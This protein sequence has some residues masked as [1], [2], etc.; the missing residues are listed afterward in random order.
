MTP[1]SALVRIRIGTLEF[2]A[3]FE[4][5]AAPRT[6]AA[7]RTHLPFTSRVIQARWSGAAGWIPLGDLDLGVPHENETSRPEPG[8]ILFHPH[9]PSETEILIPYGECVFS[10]RVG[11]LSGNHFLTV[12]V[13]RSQLAEFGRRVLWEGVQEVVFELP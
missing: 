5:A 2:A 11:P 6:C 1:R 12:E 13:G 7:F 8:D 10:S 4:D 3:R 9:G